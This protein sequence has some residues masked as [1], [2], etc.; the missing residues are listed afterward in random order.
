MNVLTVDT[1]R[2]NEAI[3]RYKLINNGVNPYI[4]C[5]EET[6]KLIALQCRVFGTVDAIEKFKSNPKISYYR[7]VKVLRDDNLGLGCVEIR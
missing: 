5:S 4:I 6:E 3:E 1:D 2:I 7:G